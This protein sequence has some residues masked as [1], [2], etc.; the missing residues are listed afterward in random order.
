M[1]GI[2]SWMESSALGQ[3]M[4]ESGPWTY[5]VVNLAHILGIAALFGAVLVVDLRLLGLWQ[6]T[7]LSAVTTVGGPVAA[8][9]FGLAAV[10]GLGLIA[11]NATEY[12]G[13][14]FLAVKFPAIALGLINAIVW[15][16]SR[17]WREHGHR[18]LSR[19][20][21]RQL[22]TMGGISLCSWLTA[23]TAGR[24]IGYW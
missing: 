5:P 12:A 4:R 19:R 22:A 18:E 2:L 14:P 24:M 13:N 20:E 21:R 23:I 1:Y 15:R 3:F 6:R 10:S 17:A 7:P 16:R 8:F 9:G 11:S